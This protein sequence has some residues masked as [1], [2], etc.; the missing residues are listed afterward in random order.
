MKIPRQSAITQ[1]RRH[2]MYCCCDQW[3]MIQFCHSLDCPLWYLRFGTF[4]RTF[5]KRNGKKSEQLFDKENFKEGKMF[6]P[7]KDIDTYKL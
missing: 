1:I 5:I 4:P 7:H 6:D 2:C 3:K